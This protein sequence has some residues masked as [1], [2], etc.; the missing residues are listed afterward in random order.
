MNF[1]T[2][3]GDYDTT[4][5]TLALG[6]VKHHTDKETSP[7]IGVPIPKKWMAMWQRNHDPT[8]SSNGN[9]QNPNLIGEKQE[10]DLTCFSMKYTEGF[11]GAIELDRNICLDPTKT[12]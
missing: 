3:Q 8:F 6:P 7:V 5:V 11:N 4:F 2:R 12:F 10:D 1:K 9:I